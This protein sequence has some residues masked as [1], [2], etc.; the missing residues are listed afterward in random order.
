MREQLT[1]EHQSG[2]ARDGMKGARSLARWQLP[3]AIL[4]VSLVSPAFAQ[5]AATG[6]PGPSTSFFSPPP[7]EGFDPIGASDADLKT[8]G[9]PP[10]PPLTSAS[11]GGWLSMVK[12]AK[13]PLVN[14]TAK[15]TGIIHRPP[16]KGALLGDTSPNWSGIYVTG[17]AGSPNYFTANGSTI[18]GVFTVPSISTSIENCTYGPYIASIWVGF[19]GYI[20]PGG[21]DV[22]QA[23]INASACQVNGVPQYVPYE[24]WYEWYTSGCAPSPSNDCG[25]T[26]VNSSS[27][28]PFSVHQGDRFTIAV[29]YYTTSPNGNA[30]LCDNTTGQYTSVWYNTSNAAYTYQGT[31]AEWVV[32]RPG[33]FS[34]NPSG[35]YNLADYAPFYMEGTYNGWVPGSG[36][37][38]GPNYIAMMC[39]SSFE[40]WY[41]AGACPI[42]NTILSSVTFYN[43]G[44]GQIFF[45]PAGPTTIYNP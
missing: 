25:E 15:T 13:R 38:S 23:G 39:S 43:S 17:P 31:S 44:D 12:A 1:K 3:L 37:A 6:G 40:Q 7:P 16:Q 33:G 18:V 14:P 22:L 34:S 28:A 27:G 9:F 42:N 11:Y 24:V 30:F 8:Y 20:S 41:P 5:P 35:F 36:P 45:A 19:D 29:T 4:S 10:R 32:E 2:S 26:V 21:S